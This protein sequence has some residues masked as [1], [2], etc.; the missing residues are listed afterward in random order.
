[1]QAVDIGRCRSFWGSTA[2]FANVADYIQRDFDGLKD[3]ILE[4][5]AGGR[6]KVVKSVTFPTGR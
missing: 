5:L 4:M 1:M 6:V 2:A 3:D